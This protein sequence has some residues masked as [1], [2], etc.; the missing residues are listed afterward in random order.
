MARAAAPRHTADLAA[1]YGLTGSGYA[2]S[3]LSLLLDPDGVLGLFPPKLSLVGH[4]ANLA[5]AKPCTI[6]RTAI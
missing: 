5:R 3:Y 2:A 4:S 6:L 1:R